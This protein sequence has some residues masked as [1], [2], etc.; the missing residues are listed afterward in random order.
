MSQRANATF[1]RLYVVLFRLLGDWVMPTHSGQRHLAYSVYPF[2][3]YSFPET[4]SQIHP[5]I[6]FNQLSGHP[7]V[8]ARWHMKSTITNTIKL[9]PQKSSQCTAPSFLHD[10]A[11]LCRATCPLLSSEVFGTY[12]LNWIGWDWI[13]LLGSLCNASC[14]VW[15]FSTP[16]W[17]IVYQ[18]FFT[19]T[20]YQNYMWQVLNI[21]IHAWDTDLT[22]SQLSQNFWNSGSCPWLCIKITFGD[23][24]MFSSRDSGGRMIKKREN[25]VSHKSGGIPVF[26]NVSLGISWVWQKR[27]R[28]NFV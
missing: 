15:I 1:L 14:I 2:R 16:G 19:L 6:T 20:V 5:E 24:F 23:S 3:C 11:Q 26:G 28:V 12:L 17:L 7:L 4:S 22:P 9:Y 27:M 21:H 10:T 25:T 18:S 8:Q 13:N